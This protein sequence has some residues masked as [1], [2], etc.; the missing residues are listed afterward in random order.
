MRCITARVI[1]DEIV[2]G[3][4][5]DIA[6]QNLRAALQQALRRV[7]DALRAREGNK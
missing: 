2:V 7:A 4:Y 1:D 6:L 3:V 5:P